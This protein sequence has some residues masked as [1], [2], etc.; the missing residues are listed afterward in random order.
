MK[1]LRSASPHVNIYS[2]C[3]MTPASVA[4]PAAGRFESGRLHGGLQGLAGV[5][6]HQ[7]E[8]GNRHSGHGLF[9]L[10]ASPYLPH[11]SLPGVLSPATPQ[12]VNMQYKAPRKL[13]SSLSLTAGL[14]SQLELGCCVWLRIVCRNV[15]FIVTV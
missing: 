6:F 4:G 3:L 5:R 9:I 8:H 1:Q 12:T 15:L 10:R 14:Y 11:A 7:P 2:T 13:F